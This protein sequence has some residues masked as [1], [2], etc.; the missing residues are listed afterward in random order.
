[1]MD[2]FE[3][4]LDASLSGSVII[5]MILL[6]RLVLSKAP[7]RYICLLWLLAGLRLLVPIQIESPLS[8]QPEV[9]PIVNSQ[10]QTPDPTPDRIPEADPAPMVPA[11]PGDLPGDVDVVV[12][13]NPG[14]NLVVTPPDRP[15][16]EIPEGSGTVVTPGDS[17]VT[18]TPGTDPVIQVKPAFDWAAV[19]P[20]VWVLGAGAMGLYTLIS[21]LRLKHRV[22][23]AVL[24]DRNVYETAAID[25][26][27]LLGYLR[28]RIY[29]P[30]GLAPQD[31]DHILAHEQTH[32]RRG[33]HWSKLLG[34][35]CLS[36]H[37]FNPLVWMAYVML[38]KDI[39]MACDESVVRNMSTGQRKAYSTALVNCAADH[40]SLSACPLAFGEVS[41]K[42][43][44]LNV[45]N[46]RK[47]SFWISLVCVVAIVFTVVC[48]MTDPVTVDPVQRCLDAMERLIAQENYVLL[49]DTV[50]YSG[51]G[52]PAD[53]TRIHI[54]N[55]EDWYFRSSRTDFTVEYLCIDGQWYSDKAIIVHPDEEIPYLQWEAVTDSDMKYVQDDVDNWLWKKDWSSLEF[56]LVEA[57][58]D[59][60]VLSHSLEEM[61]LTLH[62]TTTFIFEAGTDNLTAIEE[63][64]DD[65][66]GSVT[67]IYHF[68]PVEESDTA[69]ILS[70]YKAAAGITPGTQKDTE[71]LEQIQQELYQADYPNLLS[72]EIE[73]GI[74]HI[75]AFIGGYDVEMEQA[76]LRLQMQ[77]G[78][79]VQ[80][81][82][83]NRD[84]LH[85]PDQPLHFLQDRYI[86]QCISSMNT[87]SQKQ[88]IYLHTWQQA[89]PNPGRTLRVKVGS[90]WLIQDVEN[91]TASIWLSYDGQQFS[92]TKNVQQ[93]GSALVQGSFDKAFSLPWPMDGSL[94]AQDW[95]YVESF[96]E[97]DNTLVVFLRQ[98]A[99]GTLLRVSFTNE[100]H[101]TGYILTDPNGIVTDGVLSDPD[102]IT[103][104]EHLR[105]T[106]QSATATGVALPDYKGRELT[107]EE[108]DY[109]AELF[110]WNPQDP[111]T[112]RYNYVLASTF[113]TAENCNM[114]YFFYDG[115][116]YEMDDPITDE[117]IQ[118]LQDNGYDYWKGETHRLPADRVEQL[119]MD[120]FGLTPDQAW[121]ALPYNPNTDCYYIFH[122]D[123]LGQ[124]T[125]KFSKGYYD[126]LTGITT[127]YYP[128]YSFSPGHIVTLKDQPGNEAVP[129]RVLSHLFA[130][131]RELPHN[132]IS[133]VNQ[134]QNAEHYWIRSI[135]DYRDVNDQDL[136]QVVTDF[137]ESLA[138]R[139]H[140]VSTFDYGTNVSQ[141]VS[142]IRNLNEQYRKYS[143]PR[144]ITEEAEDYGWKQTD[145][146]LIHDDWFFTVDWD[147]IPLSYMESM[148]ES[149]YV[150]HYYR[151]SASEIVGF[152]HSQ[153]TGQLDAVIR[154][155]AILENGETVYATTTYTMESQNSN[156]IKTALQ[157]IYTK[158]YALVHDPDGYFRELF[159]RKTDGAYAEAWIAELYD[160][161]YTD[162]AEF[163][164]QLASSTLSN[165]EQSDLIDHMSAWADGYDLV[166]L[167]DLLRELQSDTALFMPARD[168]AYQFMEDITARFDYY[169]FKVQNDQK[170]ISTNTLTR[171]TTVC[172]TAD[173]IL[174]SAAIDGVLYILVEEED[175]LCLYRFIA[176]SGEPELLHTENMPD[177]PRSCFRL[178]LYEDNPNLIRWETINP[179]FWQRYL[180]E[181][182]NPDSILFRPGIQNATPDYVEANP[183][184]EGVMYA[185][186]AVQ[187]EINLRPRMWC[188]YDLSTGTY[189]RL[190]GVYDKCF[191][192]SGVHE[193]SEH[194]APYQEVTPE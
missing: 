126:V 111:T 118:Y 185:F 28:P 120:Y 95:E 46:Y 44:I 40:R 54:Q 101:L 89:A 21:Y 60:V 47:P 157:E 63:T 155:Q 98:K 14:G 38:C 173:A 102:G 9:P 99:D 143:L 119:L 122:T 159:T 147:T 113:T 52:F 74:L 152:R 106:Y 90:N 131:E 112:F 135:A 13:D 167:S 188:E 26:P 175:H 57:E 39:E 8:L 174:D 124:I 192:G 142:T 11:D 162:P 59:R 33:D 168:L 62:F 125:Q 79:A 6:L 4:I 37:W 22:R 76:L 51:D 132:S 29:L 55:G 18:V 154:I 2:F 148:E 49:V 161:F 134:W 146:D 115:L 82:A 68:L 86:R 61:E 70:S 25:S 7:R 166:Y 91:D 181:Q 32:L 100:Q 163:L 56:T 186:F 12:G 58:N 1:M 48:F 30:V 153:T 193:D 108:L 133:A 128:G 139:Y 130:A 183:F 179:V 92:G 34:F 149:Y 66:D 116:G 194:F 184:Q 75:K 43:R 96:T 45:L 182:E 93:D 109:F 110:Q 94:K 172:Y 127:L 64:I 138:Y 16:V 5:L 123:T 156:N 36:V 144:I 35:V 78:S 137:L 178:M 145:G 87:V 129:Y 180:A 3:L 114:K 20:W 105:A 169:T 140:Y 160:A 164:T 81:E 67:R 170:V 53:R 23:E 103:P 73:N 176:D 27:F 65:P 104:E 17:T 158:A 88:T 10:V 121:F 150:I 50:S 72:A 141:T 187:G 85:Y 191:F 41:V 107:Q 151:V 42:S 177:V 189:T 171:E 24:V 97:A 77:Y 165:R 83:I 84:E 31:L 136:R 15:S 80:V 190:Y 69:N 117:E 71:T 19:L